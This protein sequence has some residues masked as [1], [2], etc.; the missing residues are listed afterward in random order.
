MNQKIAAT[1]F[2]TGPVTPRPAAP[3]AQ[4]ELA[5]ELG[6]PGLLSALT[7]GENALAKR[8]DIG[9]LHKRMITALTTMNSGLSEAQAMRVAEDRK[10]ISEKLD[11]VERAINSMEGAL[12]IELE[13]MLR[14][15]LI[16]ATEQ[17]HSPKRSL[18]RIIVQTLAVF[19]LGLGLGTTYHTWIKKTTLSTLAVAVP[20]IQNTNVLPQNGGSD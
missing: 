16:D 14:N 1:D 9:E 6:L 19:T 7:D 20:Y 8:K 18:P 5:K 17:S 15:I 11:E 13:P 12:R 2:N 4:S 3:E 10:Q